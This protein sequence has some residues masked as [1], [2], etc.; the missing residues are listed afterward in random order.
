MIDATNEAAIGFHAECCAMAVF[1]LHVASIAHEMGEGTGVVAHTL[2]IDA[3]Y[4]NV[5]RKRREAACAAK[6][7]IGG[8]GGQGGHQGGQAFGHEP[9]QSMPASSP[10]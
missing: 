10:F 2:V 7:A 4:A 5:F 3:E 8:N 9:P 1:D 6:K